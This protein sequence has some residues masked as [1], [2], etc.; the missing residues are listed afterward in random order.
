M[1][2]VHFGLCGYNAWLVIFYLNH[3]L[4]GRIMNNDISRPLFSHN[5]YIFLL[6]TV[7][8]TKVIKKLTWFV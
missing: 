2:H 1:F 3:G 4:R 5:L 6:N 7:T 8:G